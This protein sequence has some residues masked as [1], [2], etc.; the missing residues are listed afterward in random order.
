MRI[1]KITWQ[2]LHRNEWIARVRF[3]P[4]LLAQNLKLFI[5][6]ISGMPCALKLSALNPVYVGIHC[7]L[8]KDCKFPKVKP[9]PE[10]VHLEGNIFSCIYASNLI[11][12][13]LQKPGDYL[14]YSD[15]LRRL[16]IESREEVLTWLFIAQS[17]YV[18]GVIFILMFCC[19]HLGILTNFVVELVF[20]K[21]CLMGS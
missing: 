15:L 2:R 12:N 13:L 6:D 9:P 4:Y 1:I 14:R 3:L 10:C 16:G 7:L 8:H 18:K 19:C 11:K 17:V 20:C 21:L 5:L